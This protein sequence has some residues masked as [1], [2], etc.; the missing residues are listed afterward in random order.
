MVQFHTN[1]TMQPDSPHEALVKAS[2]CGESSCWSL[3]KLILL[4]AGLLATTTLTRIPSMV[5]TL[6]MNV[7][8]KIIPS[9][10][11]VVVEAKEDEPKVVAEAVIS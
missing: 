1:K 11:A 4:T 9:E 10:E 8:M 5:R 6:P 2:R 7:Q 3:R